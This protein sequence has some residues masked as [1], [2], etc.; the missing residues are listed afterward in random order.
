MSLEHSLRSVYRERKI[1]LLFF[2]S[3]LLLLFFS[4]AYI[5]NL[6]VAF[7]LAF[8]SYYMLSPAV[9]FFERRG[10]PRTIA[11]ALPF[12][13]F[14]IAAF[15]LGQI[16]F[17]IL[18]EQFQDLKLNYPKFLDAAVRFLEQIEQRLTS[19][20]MNIYPIDL[21][22][23]LEPSM[24]QMAQSAAQN[25]PTI[26][27]KSV[28]VLILAPFLTYFMLVDGR[29]FLRNL[30]NLVPNNF[31]E[32]AIH[33]N[34][35]IGSQMGGFI[36]AR[37]VQS[38][39]IGLITYVGLKFIGF[40]YALMLS[41][42]AAAVNVIPYLGP[43]IGILP[44]IIINFSNSGADSQTLVPLLMVYA[45]A[46]IIDSVLITPFIVA[47]IID[48]HP[49]TVVLLVIVGAQAMGILGMIICI[50]IFCALKVSSIAIYRHFTDFRA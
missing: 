31:F 28:T 18:G 30:Y 49:V 16:F 3:A 45:V 26:L 14:G 32:L 24:M 7:I 37:V 21:R 12:L 4:L 2:L 43:V 1:K 36:R 22:A 33:M 40:P 5:E 41:L 47:K 13:V 50:P 10:L 23:R 8:T 48:L 25:L 6:L 46:Q 15:I 27:S 38:I 17:P 42:F 29:Q 39:L 35:E 34:Y 9:D 19:V 11:A 20:L 44:A